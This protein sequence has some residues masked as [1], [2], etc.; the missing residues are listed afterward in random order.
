[1]AGLL[2]D[3]RKRGRPLLL[4]I[5]LI[6]T[7]ELINGLLGHRL[8]LYGIVPR[9]LEGLRG[10]LF[11]PF[12]HAGLPHLVANTVPLLILGG[13]ASLQGSAVRATRQ[14]WEVT[15]EIAIVGGF[16]VWCFG[17]ASIHI[18]SSGLIFGYFG[19]LLARAWY[20]RKPG[21]MALALVT[22]F[23][24]SGLIWGVLPTRG[25][26]SWEGHLFGLLSGVAAA[27]LR[28]QKD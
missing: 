17:R 5:G 27:K 2:R 23:L 13:L 10:V 24:Y 3:L 20:E 15:A 4:L 11:W 12:L 8:G 19:F 28:F 26:V 18:G 16:G 22:V 25:F 9:N 21:S 7:V 1:M 6:W 14:F